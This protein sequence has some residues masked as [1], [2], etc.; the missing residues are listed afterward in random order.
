MTLGRISDLIKQGNKEFLLREAIL[1]YLEDMEDTF[2]AIGL[3][4]ETLVCKTK[5]T[6]AELGERV[7]VIPKQHHLFLIDNT[8]F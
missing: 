8:A 7:G 2:I 1:R 5:M 3:W 4:L 6:L